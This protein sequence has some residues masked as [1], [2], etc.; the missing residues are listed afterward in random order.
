[1]NLETQILELLLHLRTLGAG[2][3]RGDDGTATGKD[4][5]SGTGV[6]RDPAAPG[7]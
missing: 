6:R 4:D 1:M 3:C 5:V 7:E 2:R